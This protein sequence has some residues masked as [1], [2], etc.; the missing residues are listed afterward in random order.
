MQNAGPVPGVCSGALC[1]WAYGNC[2]CVQLSAWIE[3]VRLFRGWWE[4]V[5][6]YKNSLSHPR[7]SVGHRP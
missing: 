4:E 5:G 1:D 6:A 3:E 2:V 7:T